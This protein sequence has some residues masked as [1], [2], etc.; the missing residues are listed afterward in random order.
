MGLNFDVSSKFLA[1]C[2]IIL[3]EIKPYELGSRIPDMEADLL[4]LGESLVS[5]TG[6]VGWTEPWV[7]VPKCA[8][9]CVFGL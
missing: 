6:A 4:F 8:L 2:N 1:I 7:K 5:R 9:R 3:L